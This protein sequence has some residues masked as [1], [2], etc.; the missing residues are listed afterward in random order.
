MENLTQRLSNKWN[1]L[2]NKSQIYYFIT[3]KRDKRAYKV[4]KMIPWESLTMQYHLLVLDVHIQDYKIEKTKSHGT[5]D[6]LV[7]L[8]EVK[9]AKF[10]NTVLEQE[11]LRNSSGDANE[12]CDDVAVKIK[13]AIRNLLGNSKDRAHANKESWW[14]KK[15][16]KTK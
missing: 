16:C 6:K 1:F 14:W 10:R 11:V 9:Q 8:E 7:E 15:K 3:R 4:C 5:H 2:P 13:K 12:V